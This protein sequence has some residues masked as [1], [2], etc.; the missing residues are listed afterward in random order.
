[1]PNESPYHPRL[2]R[3]Y[4]GPIALNI[5]GDRFQP[6]DSYSLEAKGF[7]SLY[8]GVM[9]LQSD[10]W[11]VHP[12]PLN[13][14]IHLYLDYLKE[15]SDLLVYIQEHREVQITELVSDLM[16]K[17]KEYGLGDTQ[18]SEIIKTYRRNL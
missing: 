15:D 16:M 18:Y 7:D 17:F 12:P 2:V 11:E 13:K 4:S 8:K 1:M 14:G 9:I 10:P 6:V 3:P 5:V